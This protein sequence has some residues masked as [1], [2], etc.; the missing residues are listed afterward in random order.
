MKY[1]LEHYDI[2]WMMEKDIIRIAFGDKNDI[3]SMLDG[4]INW[5]HLLYNIVL[6]ANPNYYM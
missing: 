1:V 3:M 6:I 2:S 4:I 5:N